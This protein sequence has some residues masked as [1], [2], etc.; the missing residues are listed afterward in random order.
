MVWKDVLDAGGTV[1]EMLHIVDLYPTL[2]K[3]AGGSLEQKHDLDGKNILPVLTEGKKRQIR[4]MLQALG[5]RVLRLVRVRMGPLRLG[6]LAP[7][8]A[9]PLTPAERSRLV[10]LRDGATRGPSPTR[11]RAS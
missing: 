1:N 11:S 6:P 4:R 3:I 7:G 9:R 8:E 10:R 5:H 2:V